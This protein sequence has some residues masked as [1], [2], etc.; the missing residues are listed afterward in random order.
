MRTEGGYALGDVRL[1]SL[2]L[3]ALALEIGWLAVWP[4]SGAL[5]HSALFNQAFLTDHPLA[6]AVFEATLRLARVVLPGLPDT[7]LLEPLG[8][9]VYSAPA[10]ALAV[11]FLWLAAAYVVALLLLTRQAAGRAALPL[12]LVAALVF[13]TTLLFLPGLFSQ[14]VFSYIAY[15]RLSVL[16]DLN[17]YVWPPSATPKDLVLPW[18][19]TIWRTYP[20]PYGPVW[21]DVQWL[22]AR[23]FGE[24]PIAEQALAYRAF[25]QCLLLINLGLLWA[26]LGRLTPLDR[27]QRTTALAALAWNPLVL[28]EVGAN[29]HNDA[30]M[31]TFS[32]LAALLLGR[33]GIGALSASAF[34]L[35]A[36]IK[37]LSG[38]GLLW[39]G[40]ASAARLDGLH[41]RVLRLALIALL[42]AVLVVVM[43]WPWLE[44]P[45]SLEPLLDE[46][47]N[48]G[49]VNSLPDSI[50][51]A[52][53]D[54]V[55][56]PLTGLSVELAR[57]ITRGAERVL[58]LAAFGIYLVWETR[59]VCATPTAAAVTRATARSCLIYILL[60]STSVQTWYFCLPVALAL[61]LG[62]RSV[63]AQVAVGYSLLVLPALYLSYY[64]RDALPLAVFI[65]YGLLPL[66]PI[67]WARARA[68]EP[69]AVGVRDDE[70]RPERHR[71]PGAVMEQAGG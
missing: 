51:L 3:A 32:L 10:I 47:A 34:T 27:A 11:V 60:V 48:V 17:P 44:L 66:L 21:L 58:L 59:R 56:H 30:L 29:A 49:Y 57:E 52:L 24:V 26:V 6:A 61:G 23:L 1:V 39:A 50:G 40:L 16:Y 53:A 12:V 43:A 41:S 33:A 18:V 38:V 31:V 25:G 54:Q 55:L 62:W 19:A 46:T 69:A 63:L 45:D 9:A 64:V 28:F 67:L 68:H 22:M 4:L 15:G 35:G 71:N 5:S 37:Y 42:G 20:A 8:A 14:D 36:L 70:D 13:Q 2:L 7:P 65:A